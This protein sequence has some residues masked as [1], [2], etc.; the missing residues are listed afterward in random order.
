M[1]I[2]LSAAQPPS[3]ACSLVH[4]LFA[5]SYCCLGVCPLVVTAPGLWVT[6]WVCAVCLAA[7]GSWSPS[8]G[9][10]G[11]PTWT[12]SQCFVFS[13]E[14]GWRGSPGHQGGT[15]LPC[16]PVDPLNQPPIC[17]AGRPEGTAS[18]HQRQEAGAE[19]LSSLLPRNLWRGPGH[20]LTR[21]H[22][23]FRSGCRR[24]L[25]EGTFWLASSV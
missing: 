7:G 3:T 16:R 12:P 6:L 2:L 10:T 19:P 15:S 14:V 22:L 5:R 1:N 20:R 11:P 24:G 21:P 23:G 13:T 25:W 4:L 17:D 9:G 18:Q 8:W